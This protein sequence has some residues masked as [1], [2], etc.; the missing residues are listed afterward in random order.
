MRFAMQ[1][2]C[3]HVMSGLNDAR[4]S[5]RRFSTYASVCKSWKTCKTSRHQQNQFEGSR[6]RPQEDA[7][8][9]R[10]RLA[11]QRA[12]VGGASKARQLRLQSEWLGRAVEK[13]RLKGIKSHLQA[14]QRSWGRGRGA[15]G[16]VW[17]WLPLWGNTRGGMERSDAQCSNLTVEAAAEE[18]RNMGLMKT[19]SRGKQQ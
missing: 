14:L 17:V 2:Q 3:N 10:P 1:A 8:R 5:A 7:A 19:G 13:A 4:M 12:S 16:A 18:S 11:Q 15:W 9:R 6:G